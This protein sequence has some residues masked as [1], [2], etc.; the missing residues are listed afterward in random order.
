MLGLK[1]QWLPTPGELGPAG[2]RILVPNPA[3]V[4]PSEKDVYLKKMN[5]APIL[6]KLAVVHAVHAF[7]PSKQ[8][9]REHL[10]PQLDHTR[11]QSGH[12]KIPPSDLIDR[13]L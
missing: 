1:P 5:G 6:F 8:R 13:S 12:S 11:I 2:A 7:V 4:R 10:V 3:S 9:R